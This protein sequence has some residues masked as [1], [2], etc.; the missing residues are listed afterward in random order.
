MAY[1]I[2]LK[3]K[4]G[5]LM[6]NILSQ[7]NTKIVGLIFGFILMIVSF[8]ASI[9]LGITPIKFETVVESFLNYDQSMT[10]H[11]IIHTTRL[12]RAIIAAVVGSSLAVA[13]ALMQALTRNPLASP[14]ILGINA[15][16]LFTVSVAVTFFSVSS[17]VN[18]MWIAFV[19]A[20]LAVFLVYLL[21]S[22]GR[23][24]LTSMKI[25]LAGAAITALFVSFTQGILVVNESGLQEVLFWIAGSVSGRTLNML[26][27]VLPFMLAAGLAAMLM[28]NSINILATGEDIARALGQ[29]ILLVKIA[30]TIIFVVLAGGSV[31]VSGQIIFIGL[32][33]PHIARLLVGIDYRWILP[34]CVIIGSSLLLISDIV[35]RFAVSPGEL[36]IGVITALLGTP[37]FVYITRRG[38][39]Q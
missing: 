19:G 18:L 10:E 17:L 5:I 29:K 11:I 3:F 26:L 31:A 15:G 1:R 21:S 28:A 36:P 35:A 27:P 20:G 34:Y 7:K 13:G 30:I 24:G 4:E 8:I 6:N 2:L 22:V 33:V 23:E 32:M 25:V 14:G 9:S 39:N 16:A 12:P 38:F 37:F